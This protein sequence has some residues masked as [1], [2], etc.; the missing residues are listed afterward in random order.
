[1][2]EPKVF[3]NDRFL[4]QSQATLSWHDAG[5][6]MGATITDLCRTFR[7]QLYRW[8]DHLERF[9]A[10]CRLAQIV[11]LLTPDQITARAH[12]LVEHNVKFLTAEQDLALV[13]F[14]TPGPV[15]FYLGEEGGLG[16]GPV[17]YGMHTFQLPF[18][19]YRRWVEH[20]VSLMVP[21]VRQVPAVCID[22][23][24]KMRSRLHW[25]LADR[26]AQRFEPGS[27][28]LLLDTE[29]YITE[30][31]SANVLLVLQGEVVSPPR[32][33]IL[34]G[35]SRRVVMELCAKLKIPFMERPLTIDDVHH[36]E[37]A[38]LT[39]TSYCLMGVSQFRGQPVPW[40]GEIYRRLARAW[41]KEVGMDIQG[42][43]LR[44]F[45]IT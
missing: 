24:I 2:V 23:H 1:M 18:A 42:Q 16:D 4:P 34:E 30:T 12:E 3:C 38:F 44:S 22:P 32:E 28:A 39:N 13:I 36:A 10:A 8:P 35:I 17:T 7:H 43:I 5:F 15:G 41:S 9:L 19:R 11:P 26:E 33:R 20:G 45:V 14:A 29:G 31:A 37:E 25:W 6:I 40:P 27:M 21:S